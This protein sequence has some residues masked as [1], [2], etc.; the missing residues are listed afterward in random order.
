[1]AKAP[2]AGR[3]KTRLGR[4]IGAAA[5]ARFYRHSLAALIQRLASDPRWETTIAV[6]GDGTLAARLLPHRAKRMRQVSGD[7]GARMQAIMDRLPPGPAVIVGTDIPGISP[8]HIVEAFR[9]LGRHDAV[10]GPA[11]DGGYWLVGLKRCPRVVGAF[12]HVRWS[13][14][15]ALR[16]TLANLAGKSVAFC[17][18]LGD[19]DEAADLVRAG[20]NFARRVRPV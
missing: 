16:D 12:A 7:L 1:M 5:A 2:V 13:G 3:V 19:V 14:P 15:Q 10:F 17:A 20:P 11:R 9:L 18:E 8:T 6:A 4:Q